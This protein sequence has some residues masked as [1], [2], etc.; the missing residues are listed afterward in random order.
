[1]N[2]SEYSAHMYLAQ[3]ATTMA[4]LRPTAGELQRATMRRQ[5]SLIARVLRALFN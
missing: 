2:R 1:M 4:R 3:R 5:Q